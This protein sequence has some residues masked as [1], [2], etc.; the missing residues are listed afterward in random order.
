MHFSTAPV[1]CAKEDRA[2]GPE[3][4]CARA[5]NQLFVRRL[6]F[7]IMLGIRIVKRLDGRTAPETK[8]PLLSGFG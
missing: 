3:L 6:N 2:S 4:I 5:P 1:L 7:A 8:Y